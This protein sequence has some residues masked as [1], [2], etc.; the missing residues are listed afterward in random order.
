[1]TLHVVTERIYGI[2]MILRLKNINQLMFVVETDCILFHVRTEF[3]FLCEIL[4]AMKISMLVVFFHFITLTISKSINH[5][6]PYHMYVIS[7]FVCYLISFMSKFSVKYR[8][9][10]VADD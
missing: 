6:A 9:H 2:R 10:K 8:G 3:L 1:M 7:L 5:G 4:M